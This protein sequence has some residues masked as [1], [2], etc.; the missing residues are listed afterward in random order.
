MSLVK[1]LPPS[2]D[3]G[4]QPHSVLWSPHL[5]LGASKVTMKGDARWAGHIVHSPPWLGWD[6]SALCLHGS[7]VFQFPW[8]NSDAK[9]LCP[10]CKWRCARWVS[11]VGHQP[12]L[13]QV[14]TIFTG[15]GNRGGERRTYQV[16]LPGC[17]ETRFEPGFF[18]PK[19]M[20]S[21]LCYAN[22]FAMTRSRFEA[23]VELY[24]HSLP[25]NPFLLVWASLECCPCCRWIFLRALGC[26]LRPC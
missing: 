9:Q 18:D 11:L 3:T 17:G 2:G 13:Y 19:L 15:D 21:Q 8:S 5:Q 1:W 20:L 16:T 23:M 25:L 24:E 14:S 12:P 10:C 22:F 26:Y 4:I 6:T 7:L